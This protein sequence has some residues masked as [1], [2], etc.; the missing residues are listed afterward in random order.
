[1]GPGFVDFVDPVSVSTSTH[2]ERSWGK[3]ADRPDKCLMLDKTPQICDSYG[4]HY[5]EHVVQFPAL[6][7]P[8]V[9][10]TKKHWTKKKKRRAVFVGGGDGMLLHELLKSKEEDE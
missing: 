4:P 5:H 6:L 3:S 10:K 2:Q 9:V 8:P 1:M 7:L